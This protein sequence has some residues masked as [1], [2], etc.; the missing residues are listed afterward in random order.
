MRGPEHGARGP[1]KYHLELDNDIVVPF[2][3]DDTTFNV[4]VGPR[5]DNVDIVTREV[6]NSSGLKAED[7][8]MLAS[9]VLE[10][11]MSQREELLLPL[12]PWRFNKCG[13]WIATK[14]E[15]MFVELEKDYVLET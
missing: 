10:K 15:L 1:I 12:V 8:M 5:D 11:Q 6:C 2:N 4:T 9:H 13:T 3:V 14:A 7:C